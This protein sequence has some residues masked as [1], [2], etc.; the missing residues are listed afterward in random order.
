MS[1]ET[2][3]A[4]VISPQADTLNSVSYAGDKARF[5]LGHRPELNG[6]RGIAV[7]AVMLGH[8]SLLGAAADLSAAGNPL[9]PSHGLMPGGVFGVDIFFVLSGF[10]ITSVLLEERDQTENISLFNFYARRFL[11]L[12]PGLY[13]L[14]LSTSAYIFF[15]RPL[16][17]KFGYKPV[18]LSALYISNIAQSLRVQP[19]MLTHTWSLAVEEQFYFLWPI[20]LIFLLRFS[21]SR[22]IGL[23]I[24]AATLSA[25]VRYVLFTM[26]G[27]F[28]YLAWGFAP[29]RADGLLFGVAVAF[30]ANVG[31]LQDS[32]IARHWKAITWFSGAGLLVMLTCVDGGSQNVFR[33]FYI[34]AS[35]TTAVFIAGLVSAPHSALKALLS[36]RP[37]EYTGRI[38]YGLYLYHLPLMCLF[39]LVWLSAFAGRWTFVLGAPIFFL[40][41]FVVATISF[42]TIETY[43][44]SFKKRFAAGKAPAKLEK[45]SPPPS[46]FESTS[47]VS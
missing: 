35:L 18:I 24:A 30:M 32:R 45:L 41:S 29:V 31:W 39:P 26:G 9:V 12:M 13:V 46:Q 6:L 23:L 1:G 7:L 11:R 43:A 37:L 33:G 16:G 19:G 34:L 10:L 27:G 36:W 8:L 28:R 15:A 42:F 22:I 47:R 3:T 5:R 38:S 14:L 25:I 2:G 40:T 4:T 17:S 21:R 44:L 20:A